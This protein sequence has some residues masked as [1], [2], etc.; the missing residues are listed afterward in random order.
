MKERYMLETLQKATP[1]SNGTMESTWSQ[2]AGNVVSWLAGFMDGEGC[3][4]F[5]K[6]VKK[7]DSYNPTISIVNTHWPTI[8]RVTNILS[9]LGIPFWI[10]SPKARLKSYWKQD[11][12][13]VI[14]GFKRVKPFLEIITPHLY[15]KR[16]QAEKVLQFI[17]LRL[18]KPNHAPYGAE[19]LEIIQAVSR[20]NHRGPSETTR[21]PHK[22]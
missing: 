11:W 20:L 19:E 22:T 3:V 21:A 2:S 5:N 9:A 7:G 16:E 8:E 13:V 1:P 10:S 14:R 6:T 4:C 18:S 17:N 12:A 15:T